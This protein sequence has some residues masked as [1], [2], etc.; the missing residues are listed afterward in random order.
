MKSKVTVNQGALSSLSPYLAHHPA[1]RPARHPVPAPPG[2]RGR[3][4]ARG[5]LEPRAVNLGALREALEHPEDERGRPCL[6]EGGETLVVGPLRGV[7]GEGEEDVEP[8]G[9]NVLVGY[10]LLERREE[11]GGALPVLFRLCWVG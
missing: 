2:L 8:H 9:G 7:V 4:Q 10:V 3:Q 5:R 6:E 1:P 11:E